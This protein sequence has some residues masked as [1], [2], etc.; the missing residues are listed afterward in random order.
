MTALR[1]LIQD[2]HEVSAEPLARAKERMAAALQRGG[3][4]ELVKATEKRL[5]ATEDR[6]KLMGIA[7]AVDSLIADWPML[8]AASD[9]RRLETIRDAAKKK[10]G[11]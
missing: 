2:L 4:S 5:N 11:M 6:G 10:A 8:F 7:Q 1:D 3:T 9:R